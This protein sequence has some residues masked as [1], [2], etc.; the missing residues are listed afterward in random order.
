MN[1]KDDIIL[2]ALEHLHP[3]G[4][5][6]TPLH[7]NIENRLDDLLNYW[8]RTDNGFTYDTL[9]NRRERLLDLGLIEVCRVSGTY[10]CISEK[11]LEYLAGELDASDLED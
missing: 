3:A 10:L 11:G 6:P 4:M 8:E 9:R 7:W 2:E 5:A 1:E